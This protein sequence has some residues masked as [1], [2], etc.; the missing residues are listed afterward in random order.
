MA[1]PASGQYSFDARA[2]M[3]TIPAAIATTIAAAEPAPG[4]GPSPESVSRNSPS[5]ASRRLSPP[6][7]A[8]SLAG[9]KARG[10]ACA[11]CFGQSWIRLEPGHLEGLLEVGD[12]RVTEGLIGA[13]TLDDVVEPRRASGISCAA[14]TQASG[15]A[16]RVRRR[17]ARVSSSWLCISLQPPDS[18]SGVF[19]PSSSLLSFTRQREMR[20]AIVPAGM[21]SASAM[22]R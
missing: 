18:A 3:V 11:H 4:A 7:V 19:L 6:M 20:L 12:Q 15:G 5:V 22:L 9:R 16:G 14:C 13:G 10:E 1:P 21:S 17:F 8:D 2:T